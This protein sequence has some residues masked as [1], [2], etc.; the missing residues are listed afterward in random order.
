MH[1]YARIRPPMNAYACICTYTHTHPHA[2]ACICT[3]HTHAYV[4]I[5]THMHPYARIRPPMH[6]YACICTHT[7]A[8]ARIRTPT[9]ASARIC[10]HMHA[11]ARIC[12]PR[13]QTHAENRK[14]HN[15]KNGNQAPLTEKRFEG[16]RSV[17]TWRPSKEFRRRHGIRGRVGFILLSLKPPSRGSKNEYIYIYIY[18]RG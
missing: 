13:T 3:H 5:H 1:P 12:T 17:S 11:Y 9:H 15:W 16:A 6:A 14:F 2:Y 18:T 8:Y 4:R 7:Q 10:T